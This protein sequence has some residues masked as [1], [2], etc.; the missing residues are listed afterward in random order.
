MLG[1]AALA[2]PGVGPLA[3]AG[4]IASSAIPGAAATG[5]LLGAAAGG[6]TKVL[7]DHGVG[8]E[9]ASLL[10]GDGSATAASSSRSTARRRGSVRR[11]RA[12]SSIATAAIA[13]RGRGWLPRRCKR[14]RGSRPLPEQREAPRPARVSRENSSFA[15]ARAGAPFF[16]R[17]ED[18][19][20]IKSGMTGRGTPR[21]HCAVTSDGFSRLSAGRPAGRAAPSASATCDRRTA[22][23]A[24]LARLASSANPSIA[25]PQT[26]PNPDR[27]APSSDP[28]WTSR[29]PG[30]DCGSAGRSCSSGKRQS[31]V[32][33]KRAARRTAASSASTAF[34]CT[35]IAR[36]RSVYVSQG[37]PRR[38]RRW[39]RSQLSRQLFRWRQSNCSA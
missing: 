13:P 31:P 9:D 29:S 38:L 35:H 5:A 36:R 28:P 26:A 11:R 30:R 17:E 16:G 34:S 21:H 23:C 24:A 19:S 27:A 12:T 7:T 3:A 32:C 18:G 6:L 1:I 4:A 8:E 14:L 10:R 37:S 20:R 25:T 33:S 2:I 22:R 39:G 15:G